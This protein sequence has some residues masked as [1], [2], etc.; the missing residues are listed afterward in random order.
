MKKLYKK[1][2]KDLPLLLGQNLKYKQ[3]FI[4]FYKYTCTSTIEIPF[5]T[6][7]EIQLIC[8]KEN[9]ISKTSRKGKDPFIIN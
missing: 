8:L 5:D 1:R 3:T 4:Q 6:W 2:D 9:I 7:E